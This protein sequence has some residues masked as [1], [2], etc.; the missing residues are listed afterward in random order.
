MEE[1]R[2]LIVMIL[3]AAGIFTCL[4]FFGV[5]AWIMGNTDLK[6]IAAGQMDPEGYF[7][8]R[9]GRICGI[10]SAVLGLLWIAAMLA[11]FVLPVLMM[12]IQASGARG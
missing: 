10:I 8:T 1:H 9:I 5:A 7:L 6:K 2:G 4:P 3:G 11:I 12:F